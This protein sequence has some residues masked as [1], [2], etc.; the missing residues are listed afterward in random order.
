[1]LRPIILEMISL[2]GCGQTVYATAVRSVIVP[3][4]DGNGHPHVITFHNILYGLD[5]SK[6]LISISRLTQLSF[7]VNFTGNDIVV[8][9]KNGVVITHSKRNGNLFRCEQLSRPIT[10]TGA[11]L[12]TFA[13]SLCT[14]ALTISTWHATLD[15]SNSSQLKRSHLA[16]LS[17][18]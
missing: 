9:H 5:I 12:A 17:T 16:A 10:V 6:N 3:V 11:P 15:T 13:T 14:P 2:A 1:M 4:L 8:S 18:G 7:R